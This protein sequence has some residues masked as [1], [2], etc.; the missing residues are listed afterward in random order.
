MTAIALLIAA[1]VAS[2]APDRR[3]DAHL[4]DIQLNVLRKGFTPHGM[5]IEPVRWAQKQDWKRFAAVMVNCAW[6]YQD[7]HEDFL[8]ALDRIAALRYATLRRRPTLG[9]RDW[10]PIA[11]RALVMRP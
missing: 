11:W 1:N 9:R 10:L 3:A 6:D 8:A 7:R 2:D 5:T 4:F